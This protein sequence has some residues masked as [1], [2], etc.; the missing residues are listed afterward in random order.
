[1]NIKIET[2]IVEI[3]YLHCPVFIP[4]IGC[5]FKQIRRGWKYLFFGVVI[6]ALATFGIYLFVWYSKSAG[7]KDWMYGW[8]LYYP[9]NIISI[10]I[11]TSIIIYIIKKIK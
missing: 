5:F 2:T 1:M 3:F 4:F 6:Q 10:I 7:Y 8:F 9:V 11:H